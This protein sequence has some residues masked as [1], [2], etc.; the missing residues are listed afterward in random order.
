MF[1]IYRLRERR[2]RLTALANSANAAAGN[3]PGTGRKKARPL[4]RLVASRLPVGFGRSR[5]SGP[6]IVQS[7]FVLADSDDTSP[8]P[9]SI[10]D[11]AS[12]PSE[13]PPQVNLA[14]GILNRRIKPYWTPKNLFTIGGGGVGDGGSGSSGDNKNGGMGSG[15]AGEELSLLD[16]AFG[17]PVLA[18]VAA[19]DSVAAA[20][21]H[22]RAPQQAPLPHPIDTLSHGRVNAFA[23]AIAAASVRREASADDANSNMSCSAVVSKPS[24][25]VERPS[26]LEPAAGPATGTFHNIHGN[27]G[28]LYADG[29]VPPPV[30]ILS[31]IQIPNGAR[32]AAA[33]A[34]SRRRQQQAS[35]F[36]HVQVSAP[37]I[38]LASLSTV[39][40]SSGGGRSSTGWISSR[41]SGRGSNPPFLPSRTRTSL[42][43]LATTAAASTMLSEEALPPPQQPLS[44]FSYS[45][46][47]TLSNNPSAVVL[48]LPKASPPE[49]AEEDQP[50]MPVLIHGPGPGNV[51]GAGPRQSGASSGAVRS[52]PSIGTRDH[53]PAYPFS[54]EPDSG[55]SGI[56]T[57]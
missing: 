16:K 7:E 51:A 56:I 5:K 54:T 19:V 12:R 39:G 26:A 50:S 30:Q 22:A 3:Q 43:Q 33:A 28:A 6:R 4:D 14:G 46:G 25:R 10:L 17:P 42:R 13:A 34:A 47:V 32:S 9:P 52:E 41:A 21:S 44:N 53:N 40:S 36:G 24:A 1:A 55:Q 2:R 8:A 15:W 11:L 38:S 27:H 20:A 49:V 57:L 23:A 35:Q 29:G 18:A 48:D 45:G 37:S 31:T